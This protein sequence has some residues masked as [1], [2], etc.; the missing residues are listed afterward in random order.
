[1]A[2]GPVVQGVQPWLTLFIDLDKHIV[3]PKL[4]MPENESIERLNEQ[5]VVSELRML[6]HESRERLNEHIVVSEL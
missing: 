6:E 2:V 3:M 1:M 4:A 5:I